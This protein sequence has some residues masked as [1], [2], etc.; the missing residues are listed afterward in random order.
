MSSLRPATVM[1][2]LVHRLAVSLRSGSEPDGPGC[3]CEAC[4]LAWQRHHPTSRVVPRH[5]VRF[6]RRAGPG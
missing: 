3:S 5:E 2:T 4:E 1:A 6:F